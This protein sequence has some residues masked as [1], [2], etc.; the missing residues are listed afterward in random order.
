MRIEPPRKSLFGDK[1]HDFRV[2]SGKGRQDGEIVRPL[3]SKFLPATKGTVTI[4]GA[5][6]V[7]DVRGLHTSFVDCCKRSQSVDT[8]TAWVSVQEMVGDGTYK[9]V[10][11]SLTQQP[12][13]LAL[14]QGQNV[15]FCS[16]NRRYLLSQEFCTFFLV[17]VGD[18]LF[19]SKVFARH[20]FLENHVEPFGSEDVWRG[21]NRRRW[22]V[23]EPPK[24]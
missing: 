14:S 13:T 8:D 9:Q 17:R 4:A 7:F 18:Q 15:T 12:L 5:T 24:T 16:I 20:G 23:L 21:S 3:F 6:E 1:L 22:V 10:I 11:A 2:G 19:V